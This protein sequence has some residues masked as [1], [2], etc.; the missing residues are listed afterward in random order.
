[1]VHCHIRCWIWKSLYGDTGRC[2]VCTLLLRVKPVA[3]SCG[4]FL[5]AVRAEIGGSVR[6]GGDGIVWPFES[7]G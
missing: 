5:E 7:C 3:F 4:C 6:V 1:M 2:T